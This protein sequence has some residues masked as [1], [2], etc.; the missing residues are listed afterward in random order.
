MPGP[1][2][3]ATKRLLREKPQHFVS[4]LVAEGIFLRILSN[5]LKSRNIFAECLETKPTMNG[6]KGALPCSKIF[7]RNLGPTRRLSRKGVRKSASSECKS[8]VR[9]C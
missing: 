4:W 1:F 2:D 3:N 6:S 7:L 5:E 8:S 9:L